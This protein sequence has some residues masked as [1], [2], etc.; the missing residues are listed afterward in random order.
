MSEENT[1]DIEEIKERI[2]IPVDE[3]IEQLKA[4]EKTAGPDLVVEFQTLGRAF[5]EA[6]ESA[7][8][9]E[10]R[11]RVEEEVRAGVQSFASEVD[12]VIRE[13]KSSP[14]SKRMKDEAGE[15]ANK[16]E[17]SDLGR[18]ALEGIAMGLSWVS[19]EMGKLAEQFTPAEKAPEDVEEDNS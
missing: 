8:N 11:K 2:E 1:P 17:G 15:M 16:V 7:W 14:T 9:S 19:V 13:A 5:A 4:D 3:D 6:F 10:E 18:R 12:K